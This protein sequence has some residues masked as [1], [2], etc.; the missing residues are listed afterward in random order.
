[1]KIKVSKP[2]DRDT[3]CVVLSRNGYTVRQT[4]E[5]QPGS[6]TFQH[7]VEVVEAVEHGD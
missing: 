3:L 6:R 4:K 1:M 5:K 2:E 7:Y